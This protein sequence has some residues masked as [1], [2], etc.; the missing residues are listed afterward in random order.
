VH[1]GHL[2]GLSPLCVSICRFKS[3]A[4]ENAAEH[5]SHTCGFGRGAISSTVGNP[6]LSS[7][8]SGGITLDGC[9]AP[10][11]WGYGDITLEMYGTCSDDS[12]P[13]YGIVHEREAA[14]LIG[15]VASGA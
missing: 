1:V 5:C 6:R 3:C 4:R 10:I 11:C 12:P 14:R 7:S 9:G 8:C 15:T 2:C 13:L